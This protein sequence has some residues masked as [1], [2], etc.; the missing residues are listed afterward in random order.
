MMQQLAAPAK[1]PR[2][3]PPI[4][5]N[6]C[7]VNVLPVAG[8]VLCLLGLV[9]CTSASPHAVTAAASSGAVLSRPTVGGPSSAAVPPVVAASPVVPPSPVIPASRVPTSAASTGFSDTPLGVQAR[10]VIAGER[11][12]GQPRL[13]HS[14]WADWGCH[15]RLCGYHAGSG[16][17]AGAIVCVDVRRL[18]SAFGHTGWAITVARMRGLSGLGASTGAST[19]THVR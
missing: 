9:G 14:G 6:G 17:P 16:W 19:R 12:A 7:K 4:G 11:Q 18:G 8:V 13:G 5:V 15:F 2:L 10:W 1:W 3:W